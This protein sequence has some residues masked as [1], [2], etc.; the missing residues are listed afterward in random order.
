M[1]VHR[2]PE[3]ANS[4]VIRVW[5]ADERVLTVSDDLFEQRLKFQLA[6]TI[7]LGL[8]D[9]EKAA[10]AD[11]RGVQWSAFRDRKLIKIH[12]ANYFAGALLLPYPEFYR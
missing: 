9:E 5:N 8:F 6:H 4:S 11:P 7:A 10:Q 12:L 1:R 3:R 2:I